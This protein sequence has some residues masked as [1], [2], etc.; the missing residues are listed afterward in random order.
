[1]EP[2]QSVREEQSNEQPPSPQS[3]TPFD[4]LQASPF[5]PNTMRFHRFVDTL[6]YPAIIAGKA[7]LT[8]E[9]SSQINATSVALF[10]LICALEQEASPIPYEERSKYPN[11]CMNIS[12]SC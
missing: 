8:C 6:I 9:P 4:P 5:I 1:M 10:P 12:D 2:S 7:N 3:K 11:K